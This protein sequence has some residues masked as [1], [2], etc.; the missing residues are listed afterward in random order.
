M[1]SQILLS[2]GLSL[3]ALSMSAAYDVP[4]ASTLAQ[5]GELSTEWNV[6]DADNNAT[7]IGDQIADKWA[8]PTVATYANYFTDE[9]PA[10]A[11][12][13]ENIIGLTA[14][15]DRLVSPA[16]NLEAG[17]EYR[18]RYAV[19]TK[20]AE[21]T[22]FN[23]LGQ[24]YLVAESDV[25]GETPL[26][27]IDTFSSQGSTTWKNF[28]YVFTPE[29][30]GAYRVVYSI[31]IRYKSA[32]CCFTN[33]EV[34][35][36]Q[37]IP[38]PPSN[39]TTAAGTAENTR[40]LSLTLNWANPTADYDGIAFTE[41][42]T[43]E[44]INIYRDGG[45]TPVGTVTDGATTWTDTEELG[46]T[47]GYHT[48]ELE[49]VVAGASSKRAAVTTNYVGPVLPFD[50]PCS[51]S[52]ASLDDF[53]LLW[54]YDNNGITSAYGWQ[55]QNAYKLA[56]CMYSSASGDGND[57]WLF[58]P[59]LNLASA[60]T[61]QIV[62][63]AGTTLVEGQSFKVA[64]GQAATRAAM[65]QTIA[66][67]VEL[68]KSTWTGDD[69][70][71]IQF[72]VSEPGTYY[73]GILTQTTSTTGFNYF[74]KRIDIT[75]QAAA[76]SFTPEAGA[77]ES[78]TEI[79]IT[80]TPEDAKIYYTTDGTEPSVEST[81]YTEPV[82]ITEDVT[83]KAI[84]IA[85]GYLDSEVITAA[86]TIILHTEAPEFSI[87]AG[88]VERG[89]ELAITCA[90][91]GAK[92]YYTLDGTEPSAE[93]TEYTEPIVLTEDV[94]VKAIAVAEGFTAS[95][96]ATA[97]YTIRK[98]AVPEALYIF[99]QLEG[100]DFNTP[101]TLLAMTKA[102][103]TF[104]YTGTVQDADSGY[105][106]FAFTEAAGTTWDE[107]NAAR[108]S[109]AE[110][111]NQQLTVDSPTELVRGV[112]ASLKL[113]AGRYDFTVVFS[114]YEVTVTV[115]EAPEIGVT[116]ISAD[117][118]ADAEYYNLQGVRI[119]NPAAGHVY[120]VRRGNVVTKEYVR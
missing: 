73:I 36:N 30:S 102:E 104:T 61:Y 49:A 108:W 60:G 16:I 27:T 38:A 110:G 65:T 62:L 48:Y 29:T 31:T 100:S 85:E 10:G 46:L 26:Q 103:K 15:N 86:Y 39:I 115:A 56:V 47:S 42:Q 87:E 64:I 98:Y 83:I 68:T 32:Y 57:A 25:N 1:K 114:D 18:I 55:Y 8:Y 58:S 22:T 95:E 77:V 106:Y 113:A 67:S 6:V 4:Y 72:T 81:E 109:G 19:R 91:E 74:V 80:S 101:P 20:W 50:V 51:L 79:A 111:A 116:D 88:E 78:G 94:T 53:N 9:Y 118:D 33:F 66:E 13:Y 54:S 7:T 59:A 69:T 76:P 45:E 71:A 21:T 89:T 43:L 17:K 12:L 34:V 24:L 70:E 52:T 41:S 93:S 44:K 112:D 14:A 105:G 117:Y 63:N 5:D 2:I 97:A 99:G 35:E 92:I 75:T 3:T 11:F 37:F 107:I 90:T 120:I 96:V 40:A 23:P 28:G 119:V 84:A 82:V